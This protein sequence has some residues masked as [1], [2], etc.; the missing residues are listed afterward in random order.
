MS[1]LVKGSRTRSG[2]G[3]SRSRHNTRWTELNRLLG[4]FVRSLSEGLED[5]RQAREA[6]LDDGPIFETRNLPEEALA[7]VRATDALAAHIFGWAADIAIA[8]GRLEKEIK[9]GRL[10]PLDGEAVNI[11]PA[12]ERDRAMLEGPERSYERL[13]ETEK[14]VIRFRAFWEMRDEE[15]SFRSKLGRGSPVIGYEFVISFPRPVSNREMLWFVDQFRS[16]EME[17]VFSKKRGAEKVPNPLR[18]LPAGIAVHRHGTEHN[19]AHVLVDCRRA[20]GT[21]AQIPPQVWRSFDVHGVRLWAEHVHDPELLRGHLEKKGLT[22]NWKRE[23]RE[24]RERGLAPT[25]KPERVADTRDQRTLKVRAQINTDLKTVGLD[26]GKFRIIEHLRGNRSNDTTRR[27]MGEAEVARQEFMH[28]LATGKGLGELRGQ[29]KRAEELHL[30][31]KEVRAARARPRKNG[32]K[33]DPQFYYTDRQ[34]GYLHLLTKERQAAAKDDLAT[35][36]L[37]G[38]RNYFREVEKSSRRVLTEFVAGRERQTVRT[39]EGRLLPSLQVIDAALRGENESRPEVDE[40]KPGGTNPP[41]ETE[42]SQELRRERAEVERLLDSREAE[43]RAAHEHDAWRHE[44]AAEAWEDADWE[45]PDPEPPLPR[46]PVE[47]YV[48]LD[49]LAHREGDAEL[50][51]HLWDVGLDYRIAPGREMETAAV[52]LGREYVARLRARVAE[53][54][55][56]RTPGETGHIAQKSLLAEQGMAG[57]HSSEAA[58]RKAAHDAAVEYD[59]ARW[60]IVDE[61]LGRLGLTREEVAPR[62]LAHEFRQFKEGVLRMA[63]GEARAEFEAAITRAEGGA[64]GREST[65][66]IG[67][68]ESHPTWLHDQPLPHVS[69]QESTAPT[70]PQPGR[71]LTDAEKIRER[72]DLIQKQL[73]EA[74]ARLERMV[75]LPSHVTVPRATL[76]P[77]ARQKN[78]PDRT[79]SGGGRGGRG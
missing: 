69:P 45:R 58:G 60:A 53:E 39:E 25:P 44:L 48:Y 18:D 61:C 74:R 19:H 43:L 54:E 70:G 5:A 47:V 71:L 51:E 11:R 68:P 17:V 66:E 34:A 75:R 3:G 42:R 62:F 7:E 78:D 65:I 13:S 72:A 27:L 33:V 1:I 67:K 56:R 26:P 37:V 28:T 20:D 59:A 16:R 32:K 4:E 49:E 9:R 38:Y 31:L 73:Q 52:E 23:T 29:S 46:Y 55:Y 79:P 40:S 24:R 21:A 6:E 14:E 76:V 64:K 8:E 15:E 36:L 30:A 12:A 63:P 22:E 2:G 50:A 41:G 57:D 77:I 10:V 35:G